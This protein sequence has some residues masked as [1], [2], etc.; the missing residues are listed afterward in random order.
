MRQRRDLPPIVDFEWPVGKSES[1]TLSTAEIIDRIKYVQIV[2][3]LLE[4]H[5]KVKPIVYTT[6]SFLM[7]YAFSNDKLI[8]NNFKLTTYPLWIPAFKSMP[9]SL[10]PGWKKYTFWQFSVTGI[11]E[12]I[13]G[14]SIDLN[15]FNGTLQQLKDL[16]IK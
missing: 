15:Q 5:Y 9:P 12:G 10:P 1:D 6:K 4:S 8:K 11:V 3:D 14:S 2:L 7:Q 13:S 16:T